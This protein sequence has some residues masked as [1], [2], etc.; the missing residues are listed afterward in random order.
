MSGGRGQGSRVGRAVPTA[1]NQC[2]RHGIT[3]EGD[4][5]VGLNRQVRPMD[6]CNSNSDVRCLIRTEPEPG[7]RWGHGKPLDSWL[8]SR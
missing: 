7:C 3:T 1:N 4:E 8:R 5:Q 2:V 6:I